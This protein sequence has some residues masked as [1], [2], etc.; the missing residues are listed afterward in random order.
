LKRIYK[1]C[2]IQFE[3]FLKGYGPFKNNGLCH[4]DA[5]RVKAFVLSNQ[6]DIPRS[7]ILTDLIKVERD[8]RFNIDLINENFLSLCEHIRE[9]IALVLLDKED[10]STEVDTDSLAKKLDSI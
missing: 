9:D 10:C 6:G 2:H 1:A 8:A 3:E 5:N 7:K 4:Y